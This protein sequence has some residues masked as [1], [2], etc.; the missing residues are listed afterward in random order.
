MPYPNEHAVR[1]NPPGKYERIRRQNDKF[2]SGIDAIF[3]IKAGKTELQALRFDAG[4]FSVSQVRAWL[5]A[6]KYGGT[7]EAAVAIASMVCLS[8]PESVGTAAGPKTESGGYPVQQFTKSMPLGMY[9]H[10]ETKKVFDCGA[11]NADRLCGV[12]AKMRTNG[13]PVKFTQ[14]HGQG[15]D[16]VLGEVV[17]MW[18]QGEDIVW[19]VEARGE[20]AIDLCQ[21][22]KHVS[23]EI[24]DELV[25]GQKNNYGQAVVAVS[26]TPDPVV[27]GQRPFVKIAASRVPVLHLSTENKTMFDF[28]ELGKVL[29][30]EGD[31]LTDET[32]FAAISET[33]KKLGEDK[34]SLKRLLD[35]TKGNVD[36]LTAKVKELEKAGESSELDEEL[37]T[38][39]AKRIEQRVEASIA[40]G[41]LLPAVKDKV[42]SLLTGTP[43]ARPR[44]MLSIK[45]SPFTDCLADVFLDLIDANGQVIRPGEK[46][47]VQTLSRLTP[48]GDDKTFNPKVCEEMREMANPHRKS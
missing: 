23:P 40:G 41:R 6:H 11:A 32:A 15:S 42:L 37:A 33:V 5:K 14:D 45:A 30:Y 8:I 21:R 3:G 34:D 22:V 27:Q 35:E 47:K 2:G 46:T 4:K 7:V 16:A 48:G 38:E 43:D 26:M 36:A 1:L 31:T 18:R 44:L 24:V 19:V 17:E 12:F 28:E 9:T 20:N 13:I 25:D 39:R 10:P 29:A